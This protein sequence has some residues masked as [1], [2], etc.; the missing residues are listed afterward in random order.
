LQR[1]TDDTTDVAVLLNASK[2]FGKSIA[3]IL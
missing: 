1:V 2:T 3:I